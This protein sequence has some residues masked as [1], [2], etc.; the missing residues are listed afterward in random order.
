M[1]LALGTA[2]FGLP[3]GIANRRGQIDQEEA[4]RII[5]VA[6]ANH[7]DMLDTAIAYGD[8]EACL[9]SVGVNGFKVISKLPSI[10]EDVDVVSWVTQQVE[11]SVDRL[12]VESLYGL[13]LHRPDEL[14]GKDG[15]ALWESLQELKSN[16]FI[17]KLGI[18]IYSP[19]ELERITSAHHIDIVQAPFNIFDRRMETSGWFQKL[20]EMG[21]EIHVRSVFLQGLLLMPRAEV[22]E[23]FSRWSNYLDQW[24]TYLQEANVSAYAACLGFVS[25]QPMVDRSVIGV[26]SSSQ[27]LKLVQAFQG[28]KDE[29]IPDLACNDE[30]FINPANWNM[31]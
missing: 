5:E 27:L 2:Q 14:F 18:S 13:L 25:S 28:G 4:S 17:E 31:L 11:D 26:D 9:G 24:H 20:H 3:Y 19:A 8:S 6:R 15:Q 30:C 16:G 22:P 21:I 10:S 29:Q 12:M 7:V 23:K 1:K